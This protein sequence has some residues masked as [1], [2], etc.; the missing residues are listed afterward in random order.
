MPIQNNVQE[1]TIT[2]VGGTVNLDVNS[3]ITLYIID[4]AA[5]LSSNSTIQS[6]GTP[7]L[8]TTFRFNYIANIDLNGYTITIFGETM[9][10]QLANKSHE[11]V[12]TWNGAV[13][14]VNFI[15]D[16]LESNTI[17]LSNLESNE[18]RVLP[19]VS[20]TMI[21]GDASPIVINS[22][23]SEGTTQSKL[24]YQC[25]PHSKTIH[26][27]GV[28]DVVSVD[29][30]AV[31]GSLS[32]EVIQFTIPDSNTSALG[33]FLNVPLVVEYQTLGTIPANSGASV[34]VNKA[35]YLQKGGT[36]GTV[37]FVV[38]AANLGSSVT[39]RYSA[40]INLTIT[41]TS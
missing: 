37:N 39:A 24:Y 31:S 7:I 11:I 19:A 20:E 4:G 1:I 28:I 8:G 13:W 30:T 34:P 12:A 27:T 35:G 14:D 23:Q 40:Y 2:S 22:V 32:V 6:I 17:L 36:F 10:E 29:E 15:A 18:W 33:T 16:M 21:N 41:Y 25:D 26:I 3:L 5:T 9:P 38:P